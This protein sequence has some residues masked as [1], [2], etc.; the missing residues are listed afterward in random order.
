VAVGVVGLGWW[1]R[2]LVAAMDGCP[3]LD[4]LGVVVRKKTDAAIS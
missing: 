1:G 2:R 3:E 4:P